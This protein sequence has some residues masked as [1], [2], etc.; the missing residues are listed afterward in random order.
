MTTDPLL[1]SPA[2]ACRLLGDCSDRHLRRLTAA[3]HIEVRYMGTRRRIVMSSL[4]AYV[5]GLPEDPAVSA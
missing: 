3:G 2:E 1:V 4:R 5:A